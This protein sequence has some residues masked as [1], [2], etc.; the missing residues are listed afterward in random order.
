MRIGLNIYE[1]VIVFRLDPP[2][3]RSEMAIVAHEEILA[4]ELRC[5]IRLI[6]KTTGH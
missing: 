6:R 3:F 2:L 4:V 5:F 1:T